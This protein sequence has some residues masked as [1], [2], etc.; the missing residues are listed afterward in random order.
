MRNECDNI[1]ADWPDPTAPEGALTLLSDLLAC[2]SIDAAWGRFVTAMG[3]RGF[4]RMSYGNSRLRAKESGWDRRNSIILHHGPQAFFDAYIDGELFI[5]NPIFHWV[6]DRSGFAT[7]EQARAAFSDKLTPELEKIRA[8]EAKYGGEAGFTGSL[9]GLVPGLEGGIGLNLR[10]GVDEAGAQAIWASHGAELETAAR[11]LHLRISSLP[12]SGATQRLTTRQREC[13]EWAARGKRTRDIAAI[14][15]LSVP[16]V[17]KHMRLAREALDSD[18]TAQA[19]HEAQ[20]R[21]LLMV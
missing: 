8:L 21:N 10:P 7:W 2:R 5:H 14:M 4:V 16:T 11:A 19:V 1:L 13:L 15:D 3:A 9:S 18:S 12:R 6:R 20:T 17:E